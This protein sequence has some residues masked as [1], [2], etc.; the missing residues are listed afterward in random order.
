MAN[1]SR[2]FDR[3][4]PCRMKSFPHQLEWSF[5]LLC[6]IRYGRAAEAFIGPEYRFKA[7]LA[8]RTL[9]LAIVPA[10]LPCNRQN[11]YPTLNLKVRPG[12][13]MSQVAFSPPS[14]NSSSVILSTFKDTRKREVW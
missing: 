7:H 3:F 2:T 5:E 6:V 14:M 10:T 13:V 4:C 12:L 1:P 9:G 8:A 11:W